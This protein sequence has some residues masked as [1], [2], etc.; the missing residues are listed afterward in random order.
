FAWQRI[1]PE[2]RVAGIEG[3]AAVVAQLEGFELPAAAWESD[4]LSARCEAYEPMLLDTLCLTGRV[5]W[6]RVPAG[7]R[8]GGA[9]G[10][11]RST[12]IALFSRA[13]MGAWLAP[14]AAAEDQAL[15]SNAARVCE[16][17]EQRGASSSTSWWR[18]R[19]CSP[20]TS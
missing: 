8:A 10:P 11:I 18:R 7:S 14:R 20:P 12:P 4:V 2:H 13:H 19:A 16:V 17:L 15:S 3:L 5:A 9:G 1:D 6:G